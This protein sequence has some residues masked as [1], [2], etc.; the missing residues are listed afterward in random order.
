MMI[1]AMMTPMISTS[2]LL[3]RDGCSLRSECRTSATIRS[4]HN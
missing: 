4:V 1:P 2:F 3:K